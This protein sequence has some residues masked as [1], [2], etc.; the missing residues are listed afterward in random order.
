MKKLLC[1]ILAAALLLCCTACGTAASS[2]GAQSGS[3]QPTPTEAPG[4]PE[5]SAEPTPEPQPETI[6]ITDHAGQEVTLPT[7]I[8]RIVVCSIW[9]LASALTVFFNS[10][11]KLVGI[12]EQSMS[13]AKNGLLG[14]LYPEILNAETGYIDGSD[15]NLEE[16]TKLDPDVVFYSASAPAIGEQIKKAGYPAVA[17]S[18][19]KWDYNCIETLKQWIALLSEIFP[20]DAKA[21]I[22]SDYCDKMYDLVQERI[23]GISDDERQRVFFLFQYTDSNILTST[24]H[25]FGQFWCDAM[26]VKNAAAELDTDNSSP[27]NMEQIYAW[28]PDIIMV[29]NFTKAQPED[30]I[31]STI[32][33][34]DWSGVKAVMDGRVYKLPLGIYRAY[35][36]SADTPIT[37]LWM[38]KT[39]Y[40]ELFSDIDVTAEAKSYYKTVYGVELSDEQAASIF[41]PASEAAGGVG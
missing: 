10:A 34:Y 31:N 17:V 7:Q 40:P 16:L 26:G 3:I 29:T 13:A 23:S 8:D 9:P 32:G 33:S 27:V 5:P 30:I 22:V 19:D 1:L 39:I 12:P 4:S 28:D 35:T 24:L 41:A 14:Q 18:V 36:P 25:S 37:L 21:D 6:T 2:S 20:Q 38:A 11:D 15:V